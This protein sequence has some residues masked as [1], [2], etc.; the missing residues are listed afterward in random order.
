MRAIIETIVSRVVETETVSILCKFE[1]KQWSRRAHFVLIY[2]MGQCLLK[3]LYLLLFII[4]L[5]CASDL[6]DGVMNCAGNRRLSSKVKHRT[7]LLSAHFQNASAAAD[8]SQRA[9]NN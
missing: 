6:L 5:G 4:I 3:A 1:C 2:F 7:Q 8:G 9:N